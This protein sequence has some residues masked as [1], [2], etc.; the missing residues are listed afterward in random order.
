[1]DYYVFQCFDFDRWAALAQTDPQAFESQRIAAVNALIA[2]MPEERQE[3]LRCLQW[4]IDIERQRST[5]PLQA[6]VRLSDMMWESVVGEH[7]LLE[8]LRFGANEAMHGSKP[9]EMDATA[10]ILEFKPPNA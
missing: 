9:R 10:N 2:R 7:G 6:C 4:R 5:N 3:R 1:M 8:A